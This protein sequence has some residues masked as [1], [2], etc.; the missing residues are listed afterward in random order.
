MRGAAGAGRVGRLRA[1]AQRAPRG[2]DPDRGA[3]RARFPARR[4]QRLASALA[5][6]RGARGARRGARGAWARVS[7]H[8]LSDGDALSGRRGGVPAP[9]RG[10]ERG[11]ARPSCRRRRCRLAA[12]A[13][14]FLPERRSGLR[15][16][17][18]R[19]LVAGRVR[20]RG[21]GVSPPRAPWPRRVHG[22]RAGLEPRL[23]DRHL[24]V[25]A[26]ARA[27]RAVGAAHRARARRGVVRLHDPGHRRRD[28]GGRDADPARGRGAAR[29]RAR[30]VDSRPRRRLQDGAGCRA[31]PRA[32][33]RGG[34]RPPRGRRD[35]DGLQSSDRKRDT[36]AALRAPARR[37]GAA[38]PR[39]ARPAVPVRALRHADPFRAVGA[40]AVGGR[41]P[42]RKHGDRPPDVGARRRLAGGERGRPWAPAGGGD[43]RRRP[44]ADD[45]SVAGA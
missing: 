4:L 39:R 8:R 1:R 42:P 27:A 15:C 37:R 38:G 18:D 43:R 36:H 21:E 5:W 6:R 30:A 24:R 40:A 33:R 9:E 22:E 45:G 11:G 32:R 19:A 29:R 12:G 7:E 34:R 35:R 10:C 14:R 16:P 41:R 31:R 20:A 17:R 28:P 25:R 23:A 3:H 26:G 13:R 2:C 44:A